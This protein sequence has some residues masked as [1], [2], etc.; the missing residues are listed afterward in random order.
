MDTVQQNTRPHPLFIAAATSVIV[1]SALGSAAILGWLPKG[2]AEP[3]NPVSLAAPASSAAAV[4]V[5]P[6]EPATRVAKVPATKDAAPVR[7]RSTAHNEARPAP[8]AVNHSPIA[9]APME[10]AAEPVRSE[11][12][13]VAIAQAQEPP[14]PPARVAAPVCHECGVIES[15]NDIEKAG[16]GSGLG[17]V[18]GGVVGAIAGKQVGGG[19]A[20]NVMSVL[21]AVGGAVAGN[22][23]EKN[24]R[25]I[26]SY[27]IT[28]RFEDGST[29]TVSQTSPPAWRSGDR[30]RFVNGA[31]QPNA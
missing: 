4:A 12:Q 31:I 20:R 17:A 5:P 26:K 30:V 13:T 10:A 9:T 2:G 16:E 11:S 1:L 24:A 14:A 25:K 8:R 27:E 29:H 22:A 19:R 18:A 7:P 28:I 3:A 23:I 15:V 21:G 6:A